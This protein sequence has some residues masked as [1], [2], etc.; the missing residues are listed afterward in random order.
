MPETNPFETPMMKQYLQLKSQYSDCILLYRLGDFYEMFLDDAKIGAEVLNITL[1]S[2]DRGKDGRV[3]M[4]GVPYHALDA[5]LARLV[6]AGYKVAVCEQ[7]SDPNGPGLVERDVVRIVT[8][9]TLLDDNSLEKKENNYIVGLHVGAD[10]IGLAVADVST[11]SFE[12]TEYP[13]AELTNVLVNELTRFNPSEC[14]MSAQTY[15]DPAIL[16]ALKIHRNLNIFAYPDWESHTRDAKKFLTQHFGLAVLDSFGLTDYVHAQKASAGL[17]GYLKYTQKDKVGHIKKLSLFS[18]KNCLVLD[19]S[20]IVNLEIFS[21]LREGRKKGSLVTYMDKTLTSMGG[22]LLRNWILKPL[23]NKE[24]INARYDAVEELLTNSL[25]KSKLEEVLVE[26]TDIER[27]L[28]RLSVGIGNPRDLVNLKN[29]LIKVLEAKGLLQG[30]KAPLLKNISKNI[31]PEATNLI[32]YLGG[33]IVDEPPIDPKIGGILREGVLEDLDKLRRR[34]KGSKDFIAK[35]E[36]KERKR[37]GI[38]SLKVRFNNVFGYYI[39]ITRS[40]LASIPQDYIRKQT[41]VNAERFITPELK[42]HE[43]VILTADEKV[44]Q[45]EYEK[46]LEIV[47][48]V[49]G[50]TSAVQKCAQAVAELDC[51]IDFAL[52]AGSKNFVRPEIVDTGEINIVNGRHPVV[53]ETLENGDF[54]PNDVLLNNADSQLLII[55]GPNMAGKSVYI[56]QVA[57]I[58]LMAQMGCFV[59]ADSS[60]ISIVDKIFVRSGASDV[61][62]LGL[63]T[64]MVEMVETANIL[65]NATSQSLIVM[66]EIGRGTSTYDGISIAW[67]VAEYL[68]TNGSDSKGVGAR[69]K[70]LFATHYH[71]LQEL[72]N[73]YPK[74]I[75]NFQI[76]VE[77][78]GDGV[79]ADSEPVFLHK[80]K[81]GGAGHSFGIAVA[82]LAGV[83]MEVCKRA[84]EILEELRL[85]SHGAK[86]VSVKSVGS[87]ETSTALL[88]RLKSVD[89]AQTT[90]LDALNILFELKKGL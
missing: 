88:E 76:V 1:T 51:L 6:K 64:F 90:P 55:T 54:V 68:V 89:I 10:F 25:K 45:M 33:L 12:T 29:S 78:S 20:T 23:V 15:N 46:F 56:R 79:G 82:K 16:K 24:E 47:A 37:S 63:S 18:E 75:K 9:G 7:M 85:R 73:R 61:I 60:K 77:E 84:G 27:L 38:P 81:A 14:V 62:S 86:D 41:L 69:P 57:L 26:I 74:S 72:E 67:S 53:E 65:N 30:F 80:V 83:P 44:K 50:K 5:Y 11:G 17:L 8:P 58:V 13:V 28:S 3:P 87:G 36:I 31:T 43:E 52:L 71:E 40:H 4:C 70:T 2:R 48:Y 35:L 59:P 39:E 19:R 32:D 42:E 22:R 49:L 34:I 21:T 66:D